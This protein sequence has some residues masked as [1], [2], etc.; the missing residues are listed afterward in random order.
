MIRQQPRKNANFA[1]GD[2]SKDRKSSETS[3]RSRVKIDSDGPIFS[4]WGSSHSPKREP[5]PS[6]GNPHLVGVRRAMLR[7]PRFGK[8]TGAL[9]F[10]AE[11]RARSLRPCPP[12]TWT[13]SA[14]T[15]AS[16]PRMG[17][18][19]LQCRSKWRSAI[20]SRFFLPH[21]SSASRLMAGA[22]AFFILSQ[23]GR[24]FRLIVDGTGTVIPRSIVDFGDRPLPAAIRNRRT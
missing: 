6:L 5:R 12:G 9:E 16:G 17:R 7:G 3:T 11:R 15:F 2:L 19:S 21:S 8:R 18:P 20:H 1:S 4:Q 13:V 23:S 10:L 22:S 14:P 24:R